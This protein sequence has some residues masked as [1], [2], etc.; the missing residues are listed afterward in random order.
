[1]GS[2][3]GVPC[4]AAPTAAGD[5]TSPP[6]PSP[7]RPRLARAPSSRPRSRRS[8]S[9]SPSATPPAA[10]S[11]TSR[12]TTSPCSRTGGRSTSSSSP[13]RWSRAR[14]RPQALALDLGLLMDTSASMLQ[15]LKLSQEAAVA[16][17]GVDPARARPVTIFFDDD[18]RLSR[19]N[20]ENQQGLFERIADAK[21][22]GNTALYDAISVYLSRVQDSV[23]PQGARPLHGRRGHAQRALLT[24]WPA[25][26][27]LQ[28]GHHLP[29]RVHG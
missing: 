16:L 6:R 17:P 10:W 25:A 21:G 19:Y 4:L 28:P 23:R 8:T 18:I 12:P 27:P 9:P 20:S 2:P 24:T 11:P 7:A 3:A 13:A 26:H 15:Q 29:D 22:G 1:M 14:R 5:R